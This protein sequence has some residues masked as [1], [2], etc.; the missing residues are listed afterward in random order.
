MKSF[1]ARLSKV[2]VKKMLIILVKC[3][4]VEDVAQTFMS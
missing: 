1:I 2:G 4:I 3:V